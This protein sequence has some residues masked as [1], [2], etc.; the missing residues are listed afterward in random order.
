MAASQPFGISCKGGLNTNLNQLEM[1]AQP[2][3]ATKLINF[4]V[5]PDGGYRR[6][7]GYT[8]FGSTLAQMEIIKSQALKFT[9]MALQY[10]QAMVFS[11]VLMGLVGYRSIEL[12]F[13][14]T[15]ITILHLL[16]E[17]LTLEQIKNNLLLRC[18]K[19]ILLTVRLLFV[20]E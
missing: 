19:A 12:R 18:M 11:L 10:V 4:E 20:T 6:V 1:L 3:L 5:D 8:A 2:G 9:Q 13:M 7:N 17:V 14:L 15:E 16:A